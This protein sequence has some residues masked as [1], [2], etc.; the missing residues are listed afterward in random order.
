MEHCVFGSRKKGESRGWLS[1][2]DCAFPSARLAAMA[3][4]AAGAGQIPL[5]IADD[6]TFAAI[7]AAVRR[8]ATF[9]LVQAESFLLAD[10]VMALCV[11]MLV[12]A[13]GR[14]AELRGRR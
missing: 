4:A 11:G 13:P 10:A 12:A 5:E 9:E 14:W 3:V 2:H 1:P 8:G 7:K 6:E